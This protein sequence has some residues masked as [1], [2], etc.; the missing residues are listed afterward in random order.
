[1][2]KCLISA[3]PSSTTVNGIVYGDG[4]NEFFGAT[5]G[6]WTNGGE[7]VRDFAEVQ[8]LGNSIIIADGKIFRRCC[9]YVYA[10]GN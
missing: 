9:G 5:A 10:I 6:A 2:E 4:Y 3:F 1:M 7:L 8:A